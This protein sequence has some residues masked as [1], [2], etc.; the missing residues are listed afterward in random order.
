M[1]KVIDVSHHQEKIDFA[2]VKAAGVT[3]VM[4]KATEG[5]DYTDPM[6]VA[7]AQ[8]ATAAGL[9]I[10]A[11]HFLRSTPLEQQVHDFLAAIKP[12]KL[13]MDKTA[14]TNFIIT[15]CNAIKAAGYIPMV[16]SNKNWFTNYIDIDRIRA[17][18]IDIWYAQYSNA[19]PQGTDRSAMCSMWQYCSDGRVDGISGNVDCNVCYKDYFGAAPQPAPAKPTPAPAAKTYTVKQDEYLSA[20]GTKTGVPWQ[21][22]AAL[23]GLKSPYTIYPGQV[24]KLSGGSAPSAPA[25]PTAEYYTVARGDTLTGIA[26]RKNTTIATLI[27]LNPGIKNPSLIFPGQKIRIK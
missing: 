13:V 8:A 21:T 15:F 25:A 18:G 20:I 19:T 17:A 5:V 27:K 9:P 16:Y 14:L 7:N 3:G 6:F 4:I 22:I 2:R 11:Y 26:K 24:L 10:G 1:F 23:N 12:Y